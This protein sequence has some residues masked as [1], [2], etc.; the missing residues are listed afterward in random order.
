MQ[1]QKLCDYKYYGQTWNEIDPKE[2]LSKVCR[3]PDLR[4]GLKR[5]KAKEQHTQ[6]SRSRIN[7][8]KI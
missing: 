1:I 2:M 5:K 8:L 6:Q 3:G 7:L 4:R